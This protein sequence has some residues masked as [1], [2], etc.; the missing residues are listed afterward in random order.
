MKARE[1]IEILKS[2]IE[3]SENPEVVFFHIHKQK[4]VE[5]QAIQFKC[6]GKITFFI[7]KEI[8]DM[9]IKGKTKIC[10]SLNKGEIF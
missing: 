7:G 2:F 4:E 6:K 8:N 3:G 1:L 9:N 10:V 5:C